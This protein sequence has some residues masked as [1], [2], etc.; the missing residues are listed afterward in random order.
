VTIQFPDIFV[1]ANP[2]DVEIRDEAE[3]SK[4]GRFPV[5]VVT[6][7]VDLWPS[8]E[9]RPKDGKTVGEDFIGHTEDF[10]GKICVSQAAGYVIRQWQTSHM[11]L[12]LQGELRRKEQEQ[13]IASLLPK[14]K[15][16]FARTAHGR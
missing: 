13:K 14:T 7:P 15:G 9:R 6:T 11:A 1:V 16:K 8:F 10:P 2:I 12:E 4:R 3:I 5:Y